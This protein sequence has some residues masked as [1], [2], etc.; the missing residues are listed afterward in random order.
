MPKPESAPL[1]GH[2]VSLLHCGV[3]FVGTGG[4]AGAGQWPVGVACSDLMSMNNWAMLVLF[5]ISAAE[6][7]K[8]RSGVLSAKV[9]RFGRVHDRVRTRDGECSQLPFSLLCTSSHN[10]NKFASRQM[11][12]HARTPEMAPS[13]P[14]GSCVMLTRLVG[15]A[16]LSA[17]PGSHGRGETSNREVKTPERERTGKRNKMPECHA[18]SGPVLLVLPARRNALGGGGRPNPGFALAH[19]VSPGGSTLQTTRQCPEHGG[20]ANEANEANC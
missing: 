8:K 15:R 19:P 13:A 2:V 7:M 5:A 4:E 3:S 6:L 16:P 1:A 10:I 12:A 11:K 14:D 20:P 9:Q 17:S 18:E